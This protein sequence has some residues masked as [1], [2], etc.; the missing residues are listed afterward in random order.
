MK[1]EPYILAHSEPFGACRIW[2][3][4]TVKGA[5]VMSTRD[6]NKT[7]RQ[8]V[9]ADK[10]GY[11]P[12]T[13]TT[14]ACVNCGVAQCIAREHVIAVPRKKPKPPKPVVVKAV[15]TVKKPAAKRAPTPKPV[16]MNQRDRWR[17]EVAQQRAEQWHALLATASIFR[18][19]KA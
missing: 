9:L 7:I 15:K 2:T 6:G 4:R 1:H 3:G 10:L 8:L 17:I 18:L 19:A 13:K 14:F 12:N 16:P 5:P 11:R